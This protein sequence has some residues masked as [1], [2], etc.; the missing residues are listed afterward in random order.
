MNRSRI[1]VFVAATLSA[2]LWAYACGDGTT[3]PPPPPPDP[4][5]PT[6]VTVSPATAQ[7][8]ALGAMVQLS[9]EARDQNGQAMAGATVTWSSAATAVATVSSTGL[10]TAVDNG[11]ATI[12]ATAGSASGTAAVAVA[13]EVSAVAVSPAADTLVAGDT[14]RL[15]AEATDANGHPVAEA[16]F[17]WTSS[18]T[19]VAVVDATGLVTGAG[20][21][22]VEITATSSG[23]TGRAALVVVAPTP[24]TV[25]V[26]PEVVALAALGDTVR[27]TAEVRDQFGRVMVGVAVSWSSSDT[28]VAAVDAAGLVTAVGNGT[29]SI[30]A[31]AG[32]ASG[33]AAVAV[34]QEVSAVAVTP[35]VDTLVAG[36]TLRLAAEATDANGHPV[37]EAD[38][39]WA[40]SDTR[41][42][43]VDDAGLVTGVGAGEA[44][45]TATVAGVT[46]RA[47]LTV[48]APAPTAVAVTPDKVALTAL[49]QT[50]QLSAEVRDQIGRIMEGVP[51]S[52]SSADTTIA[53]VD[54]TGLVTAIGEG[55]TMVAAT[56]GQVSGAVLVTVMQSAG[57]VIV[58]PAADTVALGDTLRLG[59]E[60]F[61]E[62]GH[63]VEGAEF[64][65]SSSDASVATVDASGLVMGVADGTTTI[66]AA[67][68]EASGTSEITVENPDR[69][70]L[71]ALYNAADGPNWVNSE[72]WLT[73]A[74]L[75]EWYGVETDESGRV[76][77]LDLSGRWDSDAREYKRHGLSGSIPA[78]LGSLADLQ[79][80]D[81]SDND[82]GGA[83][84]SELGDLANL[85]LLD[86]GHNGLT[87]S[88]PPELGNLASLTGLNLGANQLTGPIPPEL[89]SLANLTGLDLGGNQLTGPIPPELGGLANLTW[90]WLS[91]NQLTGPIPPE[92]GSLAN[93]TRLWL[94]FNQLTGPIPQSFLQLDRLRRFYIGNN[95]NLCVPGSSAFVAW[96]RRIEDRDEDS[97]SVFC[98]AAD[99][100]VL[101]SLYELT[102][103]PAW[104]NFTG[105]LGD[106]AAAEWYGVEAD[107]L[108]RVVTLDLTGNGLAGRLP[109]SLG[110]LAHM[111]ELRIADNAEL[112]GYLP[113][114]LAHLSLRA[115]DYAGTDLCT[116]A[117]PSF[118]AWLDG[119]ESHEG[120]EAECPSL[121]DRE[122][123][124]ALYDA[125]GGPNWTRNENWLTDT[126]L[127]DWDGVATDR[128][129]R[130]TGLDLF[131]NGMTGAMPPELGG[132]TRL[133]S[134]SFL[135]NGELSGPIPPELG[136]L[137]RLEQLLLA[138]TALTGPIPPELGRLSKL[139][140]FYVWRTGLSGPIPRELGN[141]ANLTSIALGENELT[142]PIPTELGNLT[143]LE[144]LLLVRNALT[145]PVPPELGNLSSLEQLSL[146]QNNLTGSIPPEL[147]QLTGLRE[148]GVANNATMSGVLPASLTALREL[149]EFSAVGTGLCAPSNPAF[150]AWLAGIRKRRIASCNAG[151]AAA[152][153]LVQTVQSRDFPVPLV[154]G[155]RALLR[156]FPTAQRAT[157]AGIPA[158][159]AWFFLDGREVHVENIP[160]AT[161][162]IPTDVYEGDLSKSANAEIPGHIVQPGLEMVIEVDPDGTLDSAL[163]VA[164]RI[165]G[166]GRAT[167]EV[168]AMPT[169]DLTLVPFLWTADPDSAILD[170]TAG[171]ATDP[172]NH[173]MLWATRTLLPVGDLDVKAHEPVLA[174]TNVASRLG[175]EAIRRMEGGTGHYMAMMSGNV[176]GDLAGYAR[177][178]RLSFARPAATTIAHELGHNMSLDH[179][180]CGSAAGLD[181][182]YPYSDGSSGSWGY[183]HEGG[184]VLVHPSRPDLMSYCGPPWVSDY[185][186]TNALRYRLVD[187]VPPAA[188]AAPNVIQG[189]LLW[190]GIEADTV[191]YLEP[192]FVV[193]APPAL[194]DSAGAY[195]VTG[196]TVG[197][198]ELF[199]LSFAMPETADG[200]GSASFAFVL[201]V[202]AGWE[203]SLAS[204]T[205]TGPSG[206]A[207]LD[208]ESDHPMAILRNPRTGQVRGFLRAPP[209]T[210]AAMG[211]AG[212]AAE[213]GLE[214]L[215]SRGIPGAEVWRR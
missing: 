127:G 38:F 181:R 96:M 99:V 41:V 169:L 148:L 31:T 132:L 198:A 153:Y 106:A 196:R 191:P 159:R 7:L 49:R 130:V 97:E 6:T 91:S 32:S 84:P 26:T 137:A 157:S 201:P 144:E 188:V 94:S 64:R 113:L 5:R 180:P 131:G 16:E 90:L 4:P 151:D 2:A 200:D 182:G 212:Q 62:N 100:A 174:T 71:V 125:A 152:A 93:L 80:L 39:D 75:G 30:T 63:R 87:D 61:D 185:H 9:A 123:L 213:P 67:A 160:A 171:M 28:I 158:V 27:L 135:Q 72:E 56:A 101:K 119:I 164:K 145:G 184:G 143:K 183:D 128:D 176:D 14:L 107:L 43:V 120:T 163:G 10:V 214:V 76:V 150:E 79:S 86:L 199:S 33:T 215:F 179:A 111:T 83:I 136:N 19:R 74:P 177:G 17:A 161:T 81:L 211:A 209:P 208:G 192:A 105:W 70:A 36:D 168:R 8:A 22:E 60:A 156:V 173:E 117:D 51:V 172:A 134:L 112:S 189:L 13:Q 178:N 110:Q 194:P 98:N 68:G 187:E 166:T 104:T 138:F 146:D 23:V 35:A 29:A 141:L 149:D 121:S 24:T 142:G 37:A 126:P 53:A 15:A 207:T 167:V 42:A 133:E 25:A 47:E 21:G 204:I 73:E 175:I 103:G 46:G 57:S 69:T 55:A 20:A 203:G 50:A 147:G 170:I 44:E 59:A 210:P 85:R 40:S 48:A 102:G 108:G 165:P 58:S 186:F 195:T 118:R 66:A 92:L 197:G 155:E 65:W 193:D 89:G 95:E 12:T 140:R 88:I 190:G 77:R 139:T 1:F 114:S 34:A 129:G 202:R 205:L 154:A 115:L 109:A 45:V 11:P 162:P 52:W 3:E 122:I 116:P 206:S 82:I 54:S 18:D 124:E 78:Q